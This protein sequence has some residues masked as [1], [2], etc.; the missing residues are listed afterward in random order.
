MKLLIRESNNHEV[1]ISAVEWD[2]F[3]EFNKTVTTWLLDS[4]SCL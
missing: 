2:V 4:S 1:Y 3:R